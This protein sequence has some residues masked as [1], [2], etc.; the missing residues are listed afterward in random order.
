MVFEI[1]KDHPRYFSLLEREKMVKAA[2]DGLLA[3]VALIAHGRGE[4]FDYLLGEKTI[5]SAKTAIKLSALALLAAKSPVISVNGNIAAL[6]REELWELAQ[7]IPCPLE[8]N[9]FYRTPER[10]TKLLSYLAH[11]DIEIL[12]NNPD[13]LIPGLSSER[14]KCTKKGIFNSDVILVPLEDGDRCEAL[15]RMG[16]FVIVIDL[17]PFSRTART[18]SLTIVDNVTRCLKELIKELIFIKDN[19]E[20]FN[21]ISVPEVNNSVLLEQAVAAIGERIELFKERQ[22]NN[23]NLD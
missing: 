9:I 4:A 20:Q 1:P 3:P 23:P 15:R 10:M 21:L 8:V 19:L 16:K 7:I 18:A 12:G 6:V 17:N 2:H 22:I 14:A 5:F 11:K 13:A